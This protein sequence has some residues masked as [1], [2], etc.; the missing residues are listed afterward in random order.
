VSA[1]TRSR[2]PARA[3]QEPARPARVAVAIATR[4]RREQLLATLAQLR[5]LPEQPPI[6]VVDNASTD[7]T[8]DAV[9]ARHPEVGVLALE[10]NRGAAARNAAVRRLATPYVAFA[11]DDSWWEP[12]S[13]QRAAEAMARRPQLGLLAARVLVGPQRRLDPT[14]AEMAASPLA[15]PAGTEVPGVPVLGFVACGAVVRRTAFLQVGGFDARYGVGGEERLL[16]GDLVAAGWLVRYDEQL[17]VRHWPPPAG[18]ERRGDRSAHVVR[19]DLWSAWL[20]RPTRRLPAA[21][22]RALAH[23]GAGWQ[24]LRGAGAAL[25]GLPWILRERRPHPSEVEAAMRMLEAGPSTRS[26]PVSARTR[27]SM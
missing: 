13:L 7:G 14:C 17:V 22:L 18:R 24:T 27:Q 19:N 1:A 16:A 23:G 6:L 21:T 11:D 12:G 26:R 20:R 15:D 9:R 4:D 25:R 10:E 3:E 8:A 2:R 5:A